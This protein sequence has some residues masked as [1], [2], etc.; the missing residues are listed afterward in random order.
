[1]RRWSSNS[2]LPLG[3]SF[4]LQLVVICALHQALSLSYMKKHVLSPQ[5]FVGASLWLCRQEAQ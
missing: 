2:E 5:T 3:V 4:H 1:M